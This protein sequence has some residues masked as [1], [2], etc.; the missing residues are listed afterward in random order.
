MCLDIRY[1]NNGHNF[2]CHECG[3]HG[4]MVLKISSLTKKRS[5]SVYRNPNAGSNI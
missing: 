2:S 1:R 4:T 5:V 3:C